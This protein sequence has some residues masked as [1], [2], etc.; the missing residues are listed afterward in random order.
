MIPPRPTELARHLVREVLREGG[1]A[2]DA[3]AGNGH[4]TLFLAECAGPGGRVLAFDKQ[5]AAINSTRERLKHA[6]WL[7]RVELHQ[8]SHARMGETTQP[9]SASV[10]MFNLG[11]LP[12]GDHSVTTEKEETLIAL[13]AAATCLKPGG[14][15]S[16]VCYPGHPGGTAETA[17][18]EESLAELTNGGWRV[19]KYSM[20]G[21]RSPAPLLLT[22]CKP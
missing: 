22:A 9:G 10:V 19:A 12:G 15:L 13:D 4:D 14:M 3:T 7:D 21:T 6:G 16:V 20:L 11:Y 2:I 5:A 8:T 1:L 18:V 17:A